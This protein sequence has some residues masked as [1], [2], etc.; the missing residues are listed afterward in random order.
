MIYDSE[1]GDIRMVAVGDAMPTCRLS[2][3]TEPDYVRLVELM[4][5]ADVTFANL[6]TTVRN[7]DEGNPDAAVTGTVMSTPPEL[8]D[9]LKWMGVDIV[10]TAN[11][12][13]FDYGVSGVMASIAHLRNAR[14]P[15]AGSGATLGQARAPG[16]VETRMGRVGLV[17]TTSATGSRDFSGSAP[18][19]TVF[20]ALGRASDA[21]PDAPGRPGTNPLRFSK[22]FTVDSEAMSALGRIKDELGFTKK[23]KRDQA[24]FYSASEATADGDE[25]VAFFGGQF[26]RG[27]GFAISTQVNR[28]DADANLRQIRDAR[29]RAD[30]VIV[31]FHNHECTEAGSDTAQSKADLEEP[32]RFAIEFARA[33]IDAGADM[34]AGHGPHVAL[35][36]E[37]YKGRP[38]LHSLGNF[39]L[40]ND[41][42]EAYPAEV[43]SRF[44]LAPEAT[45]ADFIDTRSRN[46]TAGFGPAAGFWRGLLAECEFRNRELVALRLH[47]LDLGFKRTRSQRGRP[48][49]ARGDVARE[50]L[51]RTQ[52]L[53]KQYHGTTVN[54]EGETGVVVVK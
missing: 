42:V 30:W 18:E 28:D 39:V 22:T 4:R 46:D 8:L 53:S 6:E 50:I 23:Q 14:L 3:Y 1:R 20:A 36:V 48:L 32:A 41:L 11:N 9:E 7:R 29:R 15:F 35:G 34:V 19:T 47:P 40:Q 52:R 16:Y 25:E 44:G 13:T 5:R 10:A 24:H 21:R 37:I 26:R 2:P 54:I 51:E 43:Y 12:H 17:A 49:L 31:S 33:A 38:I 45:P 27:K